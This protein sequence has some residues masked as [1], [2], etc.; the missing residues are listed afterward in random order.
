LRILQITKYYHPVVGGVETFVR[1]VSER[2]VQMG[3]ECTVLTMDPQRSEKEDINGVHVV[4]FRRDAN[5]LAGLN[6]DIWRYLKGQDIAG[7]FD[8]VNIHGYHILLSFEAAYFCRTR[9]VPY[10][11]TTHYHGKGHTAARDLL[12]RAYHAE[13]KNV[14]RW[15][16]RIVCHSDYEKSLVQ[17][18]FDEPEGK[19]V[20]IP[21]AGKEFPPLAVERM[22][23]RVLYVGR[24]MK[25]K[26]LDHVFTALSV[27][28]RQG[29]RFEMRIVGA[30]PEG[31]ALRRLA[32]DLGIADQVTWLGDV[33]ETALNRD[34]R[35]AALLV[36][37]SSAEAYGLT[38]AEA[39]SAG[40]PCLVAEKAALTEFLGEPGVFGVPYPPEP[41]RTAAVMERIIS[42]RGSVKVGPFSDKIS[43]WPKVAERYLA[44][45]Q[46]AIG[47]WRE[48][49]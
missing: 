28:K 20:V 48:R 22:P 24:L 36:L 1:T 41:Q 10:V 5:Y 43:T 45:Y 46:D 37:L 49:R 13:G 12:F 33:D 17:R 29:M 47:S 34:Y 14:L 18:D 16:E 32:S 25:Y 42:L 9:R 7:R 21:N 30:G 8:I 39:L 27:L 4:R 15:A 38:V 6:R 23:G 40:T 31:E 11:I 35:S 3:H 44:V 2:Y 19:F 26:G